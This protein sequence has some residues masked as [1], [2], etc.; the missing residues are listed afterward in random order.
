MLEAIPLDAEL[1]VGSI[2]HRMPVNH[3]SN[4]QSHQ[5][6]SGGKNKKNDDDI[7]LINPLI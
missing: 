6:D 5:R 1:E 2:L 4:T 7:L 3:S